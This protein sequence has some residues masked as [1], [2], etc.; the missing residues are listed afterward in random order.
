MKVL[1]IGIKPAYPKVDGGC[2]ASAA[3]LNDLVDA[4]IE[5]HYIFLH[6]DKHPFIPEAFPE[7]LL[8]DIKISTCHVNTAV[9]KRGALSSLFKRSSY[10][11]ERFYTNEGVALLHTALD[12]SIFDAVVFDNVFAA[13]YQKDIN[14][15][16][17]NLPCYIR[18]H[19]IEF[20]IWEGLATT[21][22]NL[23]VRSYLKKLA[24]SLKRFELEAYINVSG[25]LTITTEDA[26]RIKSM[27]I[28]TP[29]QHIPVSVRIPDYQH[30][31]EESSLF[32]LGAMDWRPNVEAV[33]TILKYLPDF[34]SNAEHIRLT[35]AGKASK[36]RYDH[37]E[38]SSVSIVGFVPDL[39]DFVARQGILIAP[40][41]SGSGVRIKILE[42]MALGIPVITTT[43]GAQGISDTSGLRIAD[44]KYALIQA[45]QELASDKI[46]REELGR[47]G[48]DIINLHHNS[49]SIQTS[50][51]EF[52]SAK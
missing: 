39:L 4:G 29:V 27:N 18:S 9:S 23:L 45:V 42:M 17:P 19:N 20:E 7:R 30:N 8:E 37:L 22:Q 41:Q 6:T 15:K 47:K 51:V 36:E 31:Y 12:E 40:I 50:I 10:N 26:I 34:Q 25:I 44:D 33:E 2:V 35:I 48:K 1:L 5:V 38:N 13:R 32:F 3:F 46:K 49:K 16:F 43:L 11:V 21:A 24:K 52:I 28:Q 14:G